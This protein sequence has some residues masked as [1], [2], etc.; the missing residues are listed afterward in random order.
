MRALRPART[1]TKE[2]S[3]MRL[4]RFTTVAILAAALAAC[5]KGEIPSGKSAAAAPA[6]AGLTAPAGQYKLDPYHSN[7]TFQ[8]SHLGL[9]N[10]TA[11]FTKFDATLD[12]DPADVAGSSVTV[13]VEPASVRTDFSGDYRGTHQES[14]Y[15]TF[16]EDLAQSQKFFNAGQFPA[17]TFRSTRV[18]QT[19]PGQLRIA[20]ELTLLGQTHPVTLDARLVGSVDK[21]PFTGR[22]ALG[23]SATGTFDRS[24]FGMLHL[25]K[26]QVLVGDAVTIRFE[27]EFHQPAPQPAA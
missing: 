6:A 13:S 2:H 26:P 23:F 7:L 12:L 4:A 17:A 8:V 1:V 10:Y 27:G 25:L 9:S 14:P 18:E 15:Q 5:G 22:G 19:G 16:D 3:P 21:H 24:T 20:G 11:R